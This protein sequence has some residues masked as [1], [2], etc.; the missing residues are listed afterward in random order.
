MTFRVKVKYCCCAATL[1]ERTVVDGIWTQISSF[2]CSNFLFCKTVFK[3][4]PYAAHMP[5]DPLSQ[6]IG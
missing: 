3:K 1:S 6:I 5:V 2:I 4:G